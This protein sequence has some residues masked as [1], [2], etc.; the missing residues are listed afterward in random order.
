MVSTTLSLSPS[1]TMKCFGCGAEGHLIRACPRP[2]GK[3]CSASGGR[4]PGASVS[5][6]GR[7]L[8]GLREGGPETPGSSRLSA[9]RWRRRLLGL[10]V[11]ASDSSGSGGTGGGRR[12]LGLG[13]ARKERITSYSVE[14]IRRFLA[15]T[16]GQRAVKTEQFFPDL[17]GFIRSVNQLRKEDVFSD[18]EIYRLRKLELVEDPELDSTF[19][20]GLPQVGD[21]SG[22]MLA[23]NLTLDELHV[24]LMSLANGKAPGIDGIPVDFYKAF[25]LVVEG[26]P[27]GPEELETG[28]FALLGTTRLAVGGPPSNLLS[29]V[30]AILVN[31]F[32]DRLHWLPQAVLFLPKG[33][34]RTGA[35]SS[36]QQRCGFPAAVYPEAPVRT[37]GPGVE[38]SG[39]ADPARS[40]GGL[41]LQQSVFLMDFKTVNLFSLPVFYRGLFS[42]W[43]LLWRQRVRHE[44][45]FWLL[46]EPMAHGGLMSAPSW[47][48]AAVAKDLRTAGISTLGALMEYAGP[49]LQETARLAAGL[50][51]R[52]QRSVGRLLD[53]W[54][55]CLTG[56][57]R[58]MLGEYSRDQ[59]APCSDDPFPSLIIIM[60][61]QLKP[62]GNEKNELT[63]V[64]VC[65]VEISAGFT[66]DGL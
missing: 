63:N 60:L 59:T 22:S 11:E 52:S 45:L 6:G 14:K 25:W 3:K 24:A 47:V 26:R 27:P 48:G 66:V 21:S 56:Q 65:L 42:V 13:R 23:A 4:R 31:F 57:E 1:E 2:G 19:L 28:L 62:T 51:W 41:G 34:G 8:L 5:G 37:T 50:G 43:K 64:D 54:R 35:G 10:T 39:P 20:S 44:S 18:Q 29:R 53:H 61:P 30:Q 15:E 17:N 55:A 12:L 38:T 49:D 7:T 46:Q 33:G 16:K 40:V 32:W 36:G 58:R 9:A